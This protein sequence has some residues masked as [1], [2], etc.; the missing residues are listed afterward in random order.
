MR[1]QTTEQNILNWKFYTKTC[2]TR[3]YLT[4]CCLLGATQVMCLS[5]YLCKSSS[6][7]VLNTGLVLYHLKKCSN[8]LFL[9]GK[10]WN[11]RFNS[12][13]IFTY[14]KLKKTGS[15]LRR[16]RFTFSGF[17]LIKLRYFWTKIE[18]EKKGCVIFGKQIDI[19]FIPEESG[20]LSH[21]V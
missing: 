3:L 15:I 19:C 6:W 5:V 4:L 18:K 9:R 17:Q 11:G 21:L 10:M 2:R 16:R 8:V 14:E 20:K 13:R 12:Y 7:E 1:D